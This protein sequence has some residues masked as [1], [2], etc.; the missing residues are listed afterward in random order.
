MDFEHSVIRAFSETYENVEIQ[1]CLF[2]LS[3][4]IKRHVATKIKQ[5]IKNEVTNKTTLPYISKICKNLEGRLP[6][7][8]TTILQLLLLIKQIPAHACVLP[9][10]VQKFVHRCQTIAVSKF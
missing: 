7:S 10:E 6:T 9:N 8:N 3:Q 2:H 1:A 4:D 5:L